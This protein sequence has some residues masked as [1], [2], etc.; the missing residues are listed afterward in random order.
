MYRNKRRFGQRCRTRRPARAVARFTDS[1]DEA[2]ARNLIMAAK[3]RLANESDATRWLELLK[4]SVGEEYPS[5]EVYDSAWAA[6]QLNPQSGHE[7]WVAE[8]KGKLCAAISFLRPA[9]ENANP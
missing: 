9:D 2:P 6:A 5:K 7:T 1:A 3:V 4:A 8:A